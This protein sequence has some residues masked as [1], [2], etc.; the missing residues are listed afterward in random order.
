MTICKVCTPQKDGSWRFEIVRFLHMKSV[1]TL[2]NPLPGE[3][4]SASSLANTPT[5][6]QGNGMFLCSI[7]A[8]NL[9]WPPSA[10]FQEIGL[11]LKYMHFW[12]IS[13][14]MAKPW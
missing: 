4:L 10:G 2:G 14:L 7:P 6:H 5:Q 12:C 1:M 11:Q 13:P 3:S 8:K 9:F